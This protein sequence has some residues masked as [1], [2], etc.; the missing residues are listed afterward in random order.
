LHGLGAD[1]PTPGGFQA[2]AAFSAGWDNPTTFRLWRVSSQPAD[3]R[4]RPSVSRISF[5]CFIASTVKRWNSVG[6]M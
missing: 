5:S 4:A 6:L 3:F 2:G 1:D